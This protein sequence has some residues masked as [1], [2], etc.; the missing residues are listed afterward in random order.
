MIELSFFFYGVLRVWAFE[1]GLQC[2]HGYMATMAGSDW[3]YSLPLRNNIG[4]FERC[5]FVKGLFRL[6]STPGIL[7]PPLPFPPSIRTVS[8]SV[9]GALF[10]SGLEPQASKRCMSLLRLLISTYTYINGLVAICLYIK[11]THTRRKS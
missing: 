8:Q 2:I 10:L 6:F 5:T 11:H 1:R 9:N 4:R 3:I 7:P